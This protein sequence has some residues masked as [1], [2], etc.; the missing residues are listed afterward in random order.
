[1]D[2]IDLTLKQVPSNIIMEICG[3]AFKF[4]SSNH[5]TVDQLEEMD[6]QLTQENKEPKSCKIKDLRIELISRS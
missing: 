6:V 4:A 2:T 1:M 5:L 3:V